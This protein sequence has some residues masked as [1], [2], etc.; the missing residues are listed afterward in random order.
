MT[1]RSIDEMDQRIT[2]LEQMS[3]SIVV[4]EE[5]ISVENINSNTPPYKMICN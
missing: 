1:A 4:E 5:Y 2:R 3:Q